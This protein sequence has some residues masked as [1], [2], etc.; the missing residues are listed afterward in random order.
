MHLK[1]VLIIRNSPVQTQCMQEGR[2]S[3]DEHQDTDCEQRPG[4]KEYVDENAANIAVV[5]CRSICRCSCSAVL[6]N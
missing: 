6:A 5:L 4:S 1:C 2:E 3:F